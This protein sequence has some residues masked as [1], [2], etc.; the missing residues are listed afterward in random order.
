[1]E[2]LRTAAHLA[3]RTDDLS[4]AFG[5]IL[6]LDH[7]SF[8]VPRGT[9]FGFLGPNGAGKTTTIRVLLGLLE[10]DGGRAEVLGLDPRFEGAKIRDRSGAL[11]GDAGLYDR[12]TAED[13]LNFYAR[14]WHLSQSER[15]AR[16][17][18][19][20][21]RFGLWD[22]RKESPEMWSSGMRRKLAVLHRPALVILDEP[23]SG[24]DPVAAHELGDD[25]LRLASSQPQVHS[26]Q[27]EGDRLT[28]EVRDGTSLAPLVTLMAGAGAQIEEIRR[29]TMSLE[30]AFSA[31]VKDRNT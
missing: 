28:L 31:L 29:S 11:L 23:T 4:R 15:R 5:R 19:V 24:L 21:N 8:E 14:V 9:V 17:Q 7:L 2:P 10:P 25:L 1:M 30:D 27:A 18:E 16:I 12:L 6:A 13:N 3:I 20:L 22:R 26:I